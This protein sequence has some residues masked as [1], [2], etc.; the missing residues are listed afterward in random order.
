MLWIF[1]F[2]FGININHVESYYFG[3]K[4]SDNTSANI[5]LIEE[6]L[7]VKL[8]V[9][10]FIFDPREKNDV[11]NSIDKIVEDLGTDRIYHFTVSP[12]M[13]SAQEV[14]QW[15]F[16][17]QYLLFFEKIKEKKLHVIFRT[18]HEMNGWRYPWSSNPEKFKEAWIHVW[19]L[20]RIVWLDEENIL[21]DFSVNHRDM[22]T[23]EKPSQS[24]SL[25]KC[26]VWKKWC[27]HF[28][29]YYPW[30]EYVD[31][32]WFTFYNR[33]KAV[34]N[35]LWLSPKEILYDSNRNTY[36]RLQALNKPIII[37]EVATTSV[38]YEW[39]YQ[40]NK[41]RNEYLTDND[42]KDYWLYQLWQFLVERPEIVAAIY[43]NCDYTNWLKFVIQWEADWSIVNLN[44]D[45]IYNGFRD[46]ELF[47]EKKLNNILSSLFHLKKFTLEGEDFYISQRC[48]KD[49]ASILSAIEWKTDAADKKSMIEKLQK[50]KFKSECASQ[51]L[52]I[53]SEIYGK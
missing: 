33:W 52:K 20:S 34:G 36:P 24:A 48:S 42:R 32:V 35:R 4:S 9:V 12:D 37:D 40:Y 5:K 18:M 11:L 41:S 22:P 44:E 47:W 46:L 51:A 2:I 30:D 14:A 7:D 6:K 45:K 13:F 29:D 23:N 16:D 28:E 15:S 50:V 1:I 49:F 27:Y 21:F 26:P 17:T 3:L 43:F 10:S 38:R 8:P 53:V 25:I 39:N 19:G 31:V